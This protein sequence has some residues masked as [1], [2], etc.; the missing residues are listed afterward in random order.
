MS[1]TRGGHDAFLLQG[2]APGLT[3]SFAD[4]IVDI[5]A[6]APGLEFTPGARFAYN[7]AATPRSRASSNGSAVRRSRPSPARTS[8]SRRQA[9]SHFHDHPLRIVPPRALGYQRDGD[10]FRLAVRSITT[11]LLGNAGLLT[12]TGDLL[13][14]EQNLRIPRVG[15]RA[16]LDEMVTP[17]VATGWS[18]VSRYALGL[19]IA[20]HRGLRTIGHSGG[21]D[22]R[23]AHA[24]RYRIEHWRSRRAQ[25]ARIHPARSIAS[26]AEIYLAKDFPEANASAAAPAKAAP[27]VSPSSSSPDLSAGSACITMRPRRSSAALRSVTASCGH[28]SG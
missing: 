23:R 7:K 24:L 6:R 17:V 26:I 5:L 21:D 15:D 13:K 18:A 9:N 12:T 1:H 16:P 25:P 27:G 8:S 10:G 19:E 20:E 2:L 4:Q 3:G 11:R 28:T 22:G 14:R